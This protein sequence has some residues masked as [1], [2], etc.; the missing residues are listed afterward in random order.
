MKSLKY[1]L[2]CLLLFIPLKE[3]SA[4]IITFYKDI[5][6]VRI[7]IKT[8]IVVIPNEAFDITTE[9]NKISNMTPTNYLPQELLKELSNISKEIEDLNNKIVSLKNESEKY[10]S[11]MELIKSILSSSYQKDSQILTSLIKEFNSLQDKLFNIVYNQIPDLENQK[12]KKEEKKKEIETKIEE[13]K[14]SV[15]IVYLTNNEGELIY[16]INGRW[17]ISYVI[18]SDKLTLSLKLKF[19]LPKKVKIPS[20]KVIITTSEITPNIVNIYLGKLIANI[21]EISIYKSALPQAMPK[22]ESSSVKKYKD[23]EEETIEEKISDIGITLEINKKL[24]LENGVEII[25]FENI[26][27]SIQTKYYAIPSKYSYGLM[28]LN[29]SNTSDIPLLPGE[30][31]VITA[32]NSIQGIFLNRVV[33]KNSSFDT[34]GIAVPNIIV[35]RNLVEERIENP[36]FLGTNK[37]IVRTY[38]NTIKNTLSKNINISIIDRI[39]VPYDDRIKI[40]IEKITPSPEKN[41]EDIKKEGIFTVNSQI[42][43]GKNIE[44]IISYWVEY[45][46][47][48]Y[49]YEYEQYSQ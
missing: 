34:D 26:P 40:G 6:V 37:R 18:N 30:V 35:E 23:G 5:A 14:E 44:N 13:S 12:T 2:I 27:T 16:K 45:P 10:K 42:E 8:N 11:N 15:T 22:Y 39:P 1:F 32:G 43:K 20:N 3:I 29:I 38:K 48:K 21:R 4:E 49:Y 17:S 47:D 31:E 7:P 24:L 46:S 9:N 28:S 36:K 33:P 41:Y 19:Y 25:A